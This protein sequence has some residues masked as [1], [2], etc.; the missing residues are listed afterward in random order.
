M[1][2]GNVPVPLIG[3]SIHLLDELR[4]FLLSADRKL[5]KLQ[6]KELTYAEWT[7]EFIN[8]LTARY[9]EPEIPCRIDAVILPPVEIV[10]STSMRKTAQASE[11]LM[12]DDSRQAKKLRELG[13]LYGKGAKK[14]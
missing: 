13:I 5:G 6:G 12:Q 1:S 11:K 9:G 10:A 3:A 2:S 14:P 7:Q 8:F 4:T